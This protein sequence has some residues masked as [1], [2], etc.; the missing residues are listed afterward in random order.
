M[1][2]KDQ[3]KDVKKNLGLPMRWNREDD[4]VFPP[5]YFGIGWELNLHALGRQ[6]GL[7]KKDK[8]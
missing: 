1:E 6:V 5:K 7:I 8:K 3:D 2:Q 4:R